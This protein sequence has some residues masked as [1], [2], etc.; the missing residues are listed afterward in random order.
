MSRKHKEYTTPDEMVQDCVYFF[1]QERTY[2]DWLENLD[3]WIWDL[4]DE[5]FRA[6]KRPIDDSEVDPPYADI[7]DE[8]PEAIT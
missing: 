8:T 5:V 6:N 2:E 1:D 7:D 4:A 3:H